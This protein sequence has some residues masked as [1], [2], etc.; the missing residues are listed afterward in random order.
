MSEPQELNISVEDSVK[1]T[2]KGP[3]N[4]PV[5]LFPNPK[6]DPNIGG[7]TMIRNLD[8]LQKIGPLAMEESK[9]LNKP[10]ILV[11]KG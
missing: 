3:G 2:E 1:S 11:V 7:V 6:N 4:V 10:I 8:Q 5:P 9:R